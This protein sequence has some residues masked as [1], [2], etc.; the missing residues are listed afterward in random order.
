MGSVWKAIKRI[1]I[2]IVVVVVIVFAFYLVA[3][4][5]AGA[6]LGAAATAAMASTATIV[7]GP[8]FL[9]ASLL[10]MGTAYIQDKKQRE[11]AEDLSRQAA[12]QEEDAKDRVN[13]HFEEMED[14][15]YDDYDA[16]ALGNEYTQDEL[17]QVDNDGVV[18][19]GMHLPPLST[20]LMVGGVSYLGYKVVTNG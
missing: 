15:R 9:A 1:V 8:A 10:G 20:M 13:D 19:F 14:D 3:A 5:A 6:T 2:A 12:Q 4:Y 7:M 16:P 11:A 17:H 18:L